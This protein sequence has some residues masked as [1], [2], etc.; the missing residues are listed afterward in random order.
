ITAVSGFRFNL[1]GAILG[2]FECLSDT[3]LMADKQLPHLA[4]LATRLLPCGA[5]DRPIQK[6]TGNNDC[7]A[8]PNDAMT[9]VLHSFSHFIAIYT[10]N[11][12]ILCDLQGMV[13]RRNE[14]VLIDPQMHTYVP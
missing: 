9:S 11:D 10:N 8:A 12:A 4:F 5:V 14:M 2:V 1:E 7:G 13:D 6:F 3:H